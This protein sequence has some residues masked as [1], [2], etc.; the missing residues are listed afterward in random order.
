MLRQYEDKMIRDYE[1]KG[2]KP[3][4][5]VASGPSLTQEQVDQCRGKAVVIVINNNYKLAPWADHLYACDPSWW[6]W[7][8]DDPDLLAFKGKKWTQNQN[9]KEETER[10]KQKHH[11]TFIESKSEYG[12][13]ESPNIIHQGSN[14]GYQAINLAYHLGAKRIILLGYDM[15]ATDGKSH[16]HGDHPNGIKSS[17]PAFVRHFN[18]MSAHAKELG[19]EIINCTAKTALTCFPRK[20]LEN[21]LL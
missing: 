19:L 16:W 3:F 9:W 18:S 8:E 21:V 17:Y 15:Q 7:H 6:Q 13:S 5:L 20:K 1:D 11:L 4:V 2:V 12:L 10:F 14:S